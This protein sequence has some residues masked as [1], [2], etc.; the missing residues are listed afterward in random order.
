MMFKWTDYSAIDLEMIA[1]DS[2]TVKLN[3]DGHIEF[4]MTNNFPMRFNSGQ[5]GFQITETRDLVFGQKRFDYPR[6][7]E[8]GEQNIR[9]LIDF[10]VLGEVQYEVIP[11]VMIGNTKLF[12]DE[13]LTM[14]FFV[15]GEGIVSPEP[16]YMNQTC[17][18]LDC[19]AGYTCEESGV[20]TLET[21][22][23]QDIIIERVPVWIWGMLLVLIIALAV[24]IM[25]R[26]KK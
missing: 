18:E 8:Q 17:K 26:R 23:V 9:I 4:K 25:M 11:Y 24:I 2:Y 1:R 22:I 12:D 21:V 16:V 15:E 20:C 3:G 6:V 19:P 13:K 14:T 5:A 10:S 7:F